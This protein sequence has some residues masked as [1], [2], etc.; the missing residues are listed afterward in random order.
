MSEEYVE[1]VQR[2]LEAFLRE[3]WATALD[4]YDELINDPLAD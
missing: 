4:A 2:I 3:D 1:V